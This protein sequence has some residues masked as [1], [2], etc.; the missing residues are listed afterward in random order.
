MIAGDR[1]EMLGALVRM[2]SS[3][4]DVV[5][6]VM[7][8]RY[9]VNTAIALKPDVIVSDLMMKRTTGLEILQ[10]LTERGYPIPFVFVSS[11]TEL[12][13]L[14]KW[15]LV[16]EDDV[17]F[18]MEDAVNAAAIGKTYISRKVMQQKGFEF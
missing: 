7:N 6:V 18:E 12:M 14:G 5:S 13:R 9:L 3:R 2:L 17:S 1:A 8:D 15:S 16:H 10:G 11:N 4:F